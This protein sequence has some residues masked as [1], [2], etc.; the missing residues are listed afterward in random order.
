MTSEKEPQTEAERKEAARLEKERLEKRLAAHP[1]I[2]PPTR[3]MG[4]IVFNPIKI[5]GEPLSQTIIK[6]RRC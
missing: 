4:K 1:S 6:A 5:R 2:T 3:E